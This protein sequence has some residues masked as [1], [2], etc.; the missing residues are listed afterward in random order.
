MF[1]F[2][3]WIEEGE[4]VLVNGDGKQSRGFTYVDD[5]A[6]G[7]ILALKLVGFDVFN[8]G[9]HEVITINDLIHLMEECIGKKAVISYGPPNPA[10]MFTNWADVSKAKSVLGWEPKVS[11]R[12]GIQTLIDW[13]RLNREW[14]KEVI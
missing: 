11:L 14:A 1:R 3:K 12:Q 10:D 7:T 13:Y 2:C 6:K 5:I 8:L 4:P 9:G